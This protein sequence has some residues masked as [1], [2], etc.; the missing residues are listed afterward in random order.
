MSRYGGRGVAGIGIMGCDASDDGIDAGPGG[1]IIGTA[2]TGC[3]IGPGGTGITGCEIGPGGIAITGCDGRG[4]A[5][6]GII[7][8]ETSDDGTGIA[9]CE[10]S[11]LRS[12]IPN[13]TADW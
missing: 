5:D 6:T 9:G 13:S 4:S 7:G 8:C 1:T 12:A 11:R 10:A 3:E 2:I